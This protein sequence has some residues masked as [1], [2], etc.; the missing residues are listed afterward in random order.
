LLRLYDTVFPIGENTVK[1]QQYEFSFW[2]LSAETAESVLVFWWVTGMSGFEAAL[3]SG[4]AIYAGI[5][6]RKVYGL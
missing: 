3:I 4:L 1:R 5:H 6:K 2:E